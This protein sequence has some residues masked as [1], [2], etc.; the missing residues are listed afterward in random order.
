MTEVMA[1]TGLTAETLEMFPCAVLVERNGMV[2]ARNQLARRMTGAAAGGDS[3][4]PLEQVLMGHEHDAESLADKRRGRFDCLLARRYGAALAVHVATQAGHFGGQPCRL[5]TLMERASTGIEANP[6]KNAPGLMV[7]EVLDAL[8]QATAITNADV[9]VHVNRE[10]TRLFEYSLAEAIGRD[11]RDLI[12]P[13]GRHH[14]RELMLHVLRKGGHGEME[15]TRMTRAGEAVDVVARLTEVSL[16]GETMGVLTT[17]RDIRKQ[18]QEKERLTFSA[19]HDGLTGLPNRAQFLERVEMMLGR[20]RRRPDRRF[21]VIFLDLDGFKKVND[22]LGHA[23]GDELLVEVAARLTGCLRPQD[24]VARFGGDEFALLLDESGGAVKVESVAERI[25]REVQR[26]VAIEAQGEA[27]VAASMGVV[28]AHAG[29]ETAEAILA[30]ADAAM[31]A[32]KAGGKARHVVWGRTPR[33]GDEC[34]AAVLGFADEGC[35]AGQHED[36]CEEGSSKVNGL[37]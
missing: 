7:D 20:L 12:V 15:T 32:A 11:I 28:V 13:E 19:R 30:D 9:V 37:F 16:G 2:V 35:E 27:R 5:I 23:A 18:K 34:N 17:Y 29:Y 3:A 31:Y 4:V 6:E 33:P 36:G 8:P 21:A 25:Q 10:F 26:P 24:A 14:E 1:E 22:T